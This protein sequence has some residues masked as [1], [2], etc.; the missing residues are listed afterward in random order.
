M[1]TVANSIDT[2]VRKTFLP[3]NQ[4]DIGQAEID[5]VV[6]TLRSG[7]IT[8]GPKTKE[9]ERR[10][11]EYVGVP[12][13]VAV[14]SCTAALHLALKALGI[15]PGEPP[16]PAGTIDPG[17]IIPPPGTIVPPAPP[18]IAPLTVAPWHSSQLL[19]N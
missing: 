5:E 14:N 19:P 4:P 18:G 6:D 9:F 10:F 2:P 12:Y 16:G 13:A 11:A 17:T 3:F 8:T 7:W 1:Q 15:G